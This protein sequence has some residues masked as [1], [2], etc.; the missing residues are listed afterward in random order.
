MKNKDY[1]I[2]W[3]KGK[4]GS[5]DAFYVR[6]L[7]FIIE[8]GFINEF[9]ALDDASWHITIYDVDEPIAAGRI[10]QDDQ[11]V[12]HIG[13]ICVLEE[14]RRKSIGNLLLSSMEQKIISLGGS[15]AFLSSQ[16]QAV[17]FYKKNGFTKHGDE[18]LDEHC[19]H[20]H[21]KKRLF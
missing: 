6:S 18:Y 9:D 1:Q 8:Q 3:T 11:G 12:W 7:V 14:Y 19:P 21:M 4:K 10:Y 17:E 2:T 13:R 20:V 15:H 5:S 16:T